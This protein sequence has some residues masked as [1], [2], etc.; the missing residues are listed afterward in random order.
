[1]SE[2]GLNLSASISSS[3]EGKRWEPSNLPIVILGDVMLDLYVTGSVE[4]VSP[5]APIPV[6]RQQAVRGVPGGAANVAA[7]VVSLGG[8]AH[9][10]ACAGG[11]DSQRQLERL[12]KGARVTYDFIEDPSRPTT[13]K[14]RFVAGQHQLLRLDLEDVADLNRDIEDSLLARIEQSLHENGALI[15]SD[16]NK[17]LLTDRVLSQSISLAQARNAKV[18]VDPKR[19][20]FRWYRGANYIKPNRN[21]LSVATGLPTS[22]DDQVAEAASVAVR[23]TSASLLVTRAEHGMSLAGTNGGIV[24]LPTHAREVFD[25]SGAGDTVMAAFALGVH[26]GWEEKEAMAFANI[27]AGLSVSK[28]GTAI[29]SH[30]DVVAEQRHLTH[31]DIGRG[32]LVALDEAIQIRRTWRH[33]GLSVGFT[34]GCFDLLHVGHIKLI[35]EAAQKCDK[36]IVGINSDASVRRLK[37]PTRPMQSD[38]D[39]AE[40]LGALEDVSLVVIFSEDTPQNLIEELM[41]DLLVKGADYSI[42]QIVGADTVLNGGGQVVTVELIPNRSTTRLVGLRS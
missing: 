6:L 7:N 17:G 14:T 13:V 26:S 16:Y 2:S 30:E 3:T 36:L 11:D 35:R 15:L 19:K 38:R 18:F 28:S 10:I 4:R 32:M 31:G 1:M 37:G 23:Q 25:V 5:E 40:L 34:N 20:D 42:D 9:L 22:T 8:V 41:P 39:R 33:D 29:V 21:E 12:L 27:A 24:H